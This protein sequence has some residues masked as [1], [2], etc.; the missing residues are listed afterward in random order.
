MMDYKGKMYAIHKFYETKFVVLGITDTHCQCLMPGNFNNNYFVATWV[1]LA[2]VTLVQLSRFDNFF[3]C[4][5][6]D[7]LGTVYEKLD[8]LHLK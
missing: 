2:M 1:P 8:R 7:A 4:K 3:F 5:V 6:E